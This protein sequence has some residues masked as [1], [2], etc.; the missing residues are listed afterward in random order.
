MDGDVEEVAGAAGRIEDGDVVE[1]FGEVED[2][3][4]ERFATCQGLC[5][6]VLGRLSLSLDGFDHLRPEFFV[7]VAF[8]VGPFALE[9]L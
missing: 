8:D 6:R 5:T 7:A 3:T 1:S 4:I 2:G 9:G